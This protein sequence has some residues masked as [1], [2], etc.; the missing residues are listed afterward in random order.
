MAPHFSQFFCFLFLFIFGIIDGSI[1]PRQFDLAN[2]DEKFTACC[3]Q[4]TKLKEQTVK[5]GKMDR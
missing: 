5:D 4:E 1:L 3:K 2:P